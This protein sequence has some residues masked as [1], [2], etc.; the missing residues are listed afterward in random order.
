MRRVILSIVLGSL[1]LALLMIAAWTTAQNY[2][3][4]GPD[5]PLSRALSPFSEWGFTAGAA[6]IHLVGESTLS[7]AAGTVIAFG[8]PTLLYSLIY[9]ACF[10]TFS[11]LRHYKE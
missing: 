9:F 10:T 8:A 11:H 3:H 5:T 4:N 1:T 7:I 6:F 2:D